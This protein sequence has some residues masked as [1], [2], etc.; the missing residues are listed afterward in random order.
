MRYVIGIDPGPVNTG[1]A[2][3]SLDPEAIVLTEYY[4]RTREI[5]LERF[6]ALVRADLVDTCEAYCEGHEVVM[7][8]EAA[9]ID[10]AKPHS[11]MAIAEVI[12]IVRGVAGQF[13]LPLHVIQAAKWKLAACGD[14]NGLYPFIRRCLFTML[15]NSR[16][17]K[18]M[19]EHEIAALGIALCAG[20]IEENAERVGAR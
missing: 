7:A 20:R 9:Y 15:K 5:S 2:I 10:R 18:D 16:I 13:D 3:I 6:L 12:S 4:H 8:C 14:G 19:S 1:L 17:P 11:G